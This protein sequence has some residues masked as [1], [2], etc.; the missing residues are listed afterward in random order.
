VQNTTLNAIAWK[1]FSRLTLTLLAAIAVPRILL[2]QESIPPQMA[3]KLEQKFNEADKDKDGIL[4]LAEAKEGTP[5]RIWENFDRI[6]V[7]RS[8]TIALEEVRQAFASGA[9][10]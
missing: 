2:A 8:G 7:A 6:D 5:S 3:Q 10:D 1:F 4:T 9:I